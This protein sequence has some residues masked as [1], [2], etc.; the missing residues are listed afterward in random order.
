MA[1]AGPR[2]VT[3]GISSGANYPFKGRID[4]V[5]IY[6]YAR[7]P[8]Q[9]A[10]DYNRGAPVAHW[11][12]DECEGTV[13]H[14]SS[15]NGNHGTINIGPSG[16]QSTA[17]T[18]QTSGAWANG[19]DG[20]FNGSLNFDGTDDVVNL[21]NPSRIANLST[22]ITAAVWIKPTSGGG[23]L[24]RG[25]GSNY[26]YLLQI[27]SSSQIR[28]RLWETLGDA[29]SGINYLV[30]GLN[31]F[32]SWNHIAFTYDGNSVKIFV[33]AELKSNTPRSA[34]IATGETTQLGEYPGGG[35]R[36]LT[37]QIDD[38]RIYN[39]A[40]SPAQILKVYNQGQAV[41]FTRAN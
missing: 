31:L 26:N 39:Y 10:Y 22:N 3:N 14:D 7:T 18:C 38:V 36:Y 17:G 13:A 11:R 33:N 30:P 12:F 37:G 21:G 8:A 35:P 28:L 19:K 27:E 25:A 23:V 34:P 32:N 1:V 41:N 29:G 2:N 4:H 24:Y 6:D 40:L 15:G 9:I 5:K 16:S 20:K